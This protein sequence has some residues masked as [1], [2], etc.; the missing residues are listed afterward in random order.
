MRIALGQ[1]RLVDR[2]PETEVEMAEHIVVPTP[3][4]SDKNGGA[5]QQGTRE[6]IERLMNELG[7]QGFRFVAQIE[8]TSYQQP[9]CIPALFGASPI[10][11]RQHFLVFV[12]D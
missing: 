8:S 1:P 10:P 2:I 6:A 12:R 9:G 7:A 5:A 3:A 11:M 4:V